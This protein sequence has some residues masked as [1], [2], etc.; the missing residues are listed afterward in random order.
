MVYRHICR[1]NTHKIKTKVRKH[2]LKKKEKERKGEKAGGTKREKER[3]GGRKGVR[4]A[5]KKGKENQHY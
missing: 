4:E 3:K 1:Q 2:F 5:G